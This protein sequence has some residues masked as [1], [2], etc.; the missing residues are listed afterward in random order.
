MAL[1]PGGAKNKGASG[2][3]EAAE[4]LKGWALAVGHDIDPTRNLEQ[5]RGGGYD[6]N[7]VVGLGIEVKRVESNSINSWWKQTER[8]ADDDGTI[9]FLMH[10]RNRQPWRF[11]VRTGVAMASGDNWAHFF[12]TVDLEL[13]QARVWFQEYITITLGRGELKPPPPPPGAAP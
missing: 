3:R 9:P 1:R 6:L 11:R 7:G 10:R 2:E 4:L 12:L 13:E 5:V 8:Q